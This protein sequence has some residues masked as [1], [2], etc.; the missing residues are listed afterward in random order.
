MSFLSEI[1][2]FDDI[3]LKAREY[4]KVSK[5][6]VYICKAYGEPKAAD[7]AKKV[8]CLSCR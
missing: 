5:H 7:D 3:G 2:R 8:F 6:A 4:E 1:L